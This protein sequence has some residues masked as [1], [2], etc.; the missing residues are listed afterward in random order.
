MIT[1]IVLALVMQLTASRSLQP[2]DIERMMDRDGAKKTLEVLFEDDR[3]WDRILTSIAK[4]QPAWLNVAANLKAV[5]D[6]GASERLAMATQEALPKNAPEVLRL[7]SRGAFD[8]D[9]AC[10]G[11]GFDQ[12]ENERPIRVLLGL[13]DKRVAV[14]SRI[15]APQKNGH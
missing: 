14:V 6:A 9:V 12:I 11:Y 1:A 8:V 7:V 15:R 13:V 10:S 2:A 5:S 3:R 4:G